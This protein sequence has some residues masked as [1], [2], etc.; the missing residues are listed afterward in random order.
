M[1]SQKQLWFWDPITLSQIFSKT[2]ISF[3]LLISFAGAR[4]KLEFDVG[5][6]VQVLSDKAFR[7]LKENEFEA[8]GNVIITYGNQVIYGEKA[9]LSFETGQIRMVGNVRYVSPEITLYSSELNYN[10]RT[11]D[12]SVGNARV[13]S[14]NYVVLGKELRRT[15]EGIIV[16]KDAEYTTCKDCPESWSIFG[17][18]VTITVGEYIRIWHAYIKAKGVVI[19]YLPYLVLP[20]K[21]ERESGLLFPTLSLGNREGVLFQVPYYWAINNHSDMTLSPSLFGQR[22]YGSEFQYRHIF[23][24]KTWFEID[25]LYAYDSIYAPGKL[26]F[27]KSGDRTHRYFAGYEHHFSTSEHWNHHFYFDGLNDLD[28]VRDFDFYTTESIMGPDLGGSGFVNFRTDTLQVSLEGNFRRNQLF[29]NPKGVDH[30]YVQILPRI[31]FSSTPFSLYQSDASFFNGIFFGL[32]SDY[33]VFKQN[34]KEESRYIRN[35]ARSN[36]RP[37][38]EMAIGHIGAVQFRSTTSFDYQYYH[39]DHLQKNRSFSKGAHYPPD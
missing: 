38:L 16:G 7:R 10:L 35:A 5:E 36:A 30:R 29:P 8:L 3:S 27:D 1:T 13:L 9:S 2:F 18:E 14:D 11:K 23:A 17:R 21:Q 37:Y 32:E 26:S 25:T 28:T 12:F 33:T 24:P 15:P 31:D 34:H 20:I 39:F 19:M 6:K 22:G 4:E